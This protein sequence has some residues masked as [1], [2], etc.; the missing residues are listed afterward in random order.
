[1][2]AETKT[3]LTADTIQCVQQLIQANIDSAE[4]LEAA[5]KRLNDVIVGGRFDQ[6]ASK[7]RNYAEEL[8]TYVAANHELPA[9]SGTVAETARR[10]WLDIRA[11]VNGGDSYVVLIEADRA[12]ERIKQLY[13]DVLTRCAGNALSGVLHRQFAELKQ[14]HDEVRG[15]REAR[16]HVRRGWE[17]PE[18]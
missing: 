6:L 11:V 18:E 10:W 2:R 4:I 3:N 17:E 7:R 14:G 12:E 1:M 16:K 9:D 8:Q 13:E 15:L 5:A